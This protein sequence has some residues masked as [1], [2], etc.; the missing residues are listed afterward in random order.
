MLAAKSRANFEKIKTWK[1]SCRLSI[2]QYL[3]KDFVSGLP[4]PQGKAEPLMQEVELTRASPS[5]PGGNLFLDLEGRTMAAGSVLGSVG[6][7]DN[8]DGL[9][10]STLSLS[11]AQSGWFTIGTGANGP[12]LYLRPAPTS[13]S[14][15]TSTST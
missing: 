10:S 4:V 14:S 7:A 9:G 13:T 8:P 15:I 5:T 3:S 12:A 1:G 6:L 11:G 2:R